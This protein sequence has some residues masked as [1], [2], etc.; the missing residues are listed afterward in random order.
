MLASAERKS[1]YVIFTNS[2]SG[3]DVMKELINGDTLLNRF[4]RD[5]LVLPFT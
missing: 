2:D 4:V 5:D 1:G 3:F